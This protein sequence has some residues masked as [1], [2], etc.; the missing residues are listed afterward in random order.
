MAITK[1]KDYDSVSVGGDFKVLT[2]GAYICRLIM[3]EEMESSGGKPML[4]IAFDIID[5]EYKN[6]FMDLY[7]SRK[8]SNTDPTKEVKYPFEGQK[9]I[10]VDDYKDP[11]KP[12][13]QFKS[14]ITAVED[15]GTEVWTP[16]GELN[17]N[18]VKKAEVGVVFRREE[19]EYEGKT[20]WR[21]VPWG[22]RSIEAVAAGDCYIPEDKPLSETSGTGFSQPSVSADSFSA[23]EDDIPF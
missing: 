17:L 14:F 19:Q 23:A 11:S 13:R 21:T 1:Q 22:F 7:G 16:K 10:M 4:H 2:K 8:K 3:A 6:Y 15:S 12:S 5:D 18:E 9:W 20:S